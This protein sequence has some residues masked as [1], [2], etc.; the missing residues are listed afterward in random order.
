MGLEPKG[1]AEKEN[2]EKENASGTSALPG[3]R[4]PGSAAGKPIIH[5]DF[6]DPLPEELLDAFEG[7]SVEGPAPERRPSLGGE[8][9]TIEEVAEALRFEL[10]APPEAL[11]GE[12]GLAELWGAKIVD[13]GLLVRFAGGQWFRLTITREPGRKV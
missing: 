1:K 5:A 10:C 7:T 3:N 11:E 8:P 9:L 6:N 12:T 2:T 4:R 13:G